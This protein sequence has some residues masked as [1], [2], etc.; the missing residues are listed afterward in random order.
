MA[1]GT[2]HAALSILVK[3]GV[4]ARAG[5]GYYMKKSAAFKTLRLKE[6]VV[7]D[8]FTIEASHEYDLDKLFPSAVEVE[9]EIVEI[10]SEPDSTVTEV[11]ILDVMPEVEIDSPVE[12][13]PSVDQPVETVTEIEEAQRS[14][15][16][17][18]MPEVET[19]EAASTTLVLANNTQAILA[20]STQAKIE[21]CKNEI[22]KRK[23]RIQKLRSES[24]EAAVD[25]EDLKAIG[26]P[27][28]EQIK[29]KE[30]TIACH[31]VFIRDLAIEVTQLT[32]ALG[33]LNRMK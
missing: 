32:A 28:D 4:L 30:H 19:P 25:I 12:E 21:L 29:D 7:L 23:K 6:T 15:V 16:F 5:A 20:K 2:F 18:P 31:D 9:P 3:R 22:A 13:E 1:K 10:A 8:G 24:A 33:V 17:A 26:L 27:M 11:E 14:D